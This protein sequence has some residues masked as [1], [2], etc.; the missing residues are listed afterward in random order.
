MPGQDFGGFGSENGGSNSLDFPTP[1]LEP[2]KVLTGKDFDNGAEVD[3][4]E[5]GTIESRKLAMSSSSLGKLALE[6][7]DSLR[8]DKESI[9]LRMSSS[10]LIFK[11][12][13]LGDPEV[14]FLRKT[15]LEHPLE[16]PLVGK[17]LGFRSPQP[18]LRSE[19]EGNL[20]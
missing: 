13:P 14:H 19:A 4:F 2:G 10:F 1:S 16:F 17:A 20:A 12:D 5:K 15:R 18:R 8:K 7:D 9:W 11:L 3:F 6:E